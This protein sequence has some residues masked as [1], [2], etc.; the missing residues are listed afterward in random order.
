[1]HVGDPVAQA[2]ED[3]PAHHRVIR[4]QRIAG[5]RV[6]RIAGTIGREEIVGVVVEPAKRQRG[7]AVVAFRRMVVD[8][9]Q[10]DLD[11]RAVQRLDHVPELVDRRERIGTRAV[12]RV[13][14]EE[15]DRRIAPMVDETR[16]AVPRV[17]LEDRQQL[18]RRDAEILQIGNLLDEADVGAAPGRRHA[19]ARMPGEPATC[20]S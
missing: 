9:V 10:D 18:D 12:P 15:R 13:R 8:D 11:A 7:A 3:Q 19:G 4:V 16:R 6:V 20:I 2:V 14:R 5:P 1:V 17:E